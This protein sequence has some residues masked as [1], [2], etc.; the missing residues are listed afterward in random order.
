[1][2]LTK[3]ELKIERRR[4]HEIYLTHD[5]KAFREFITDR[6]KIKPELAP[7]ITATEEVLSELM[8][9]MKSQLMYLGPDWQ[10]ARNHLRYKQFWEDGD[11]AQDEIPE[12]VTCKWFQEAPNKTESS[13]MQMG[14]TPHDIA[15]KAFKPF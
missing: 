4:L 8:F 5:T 1:M 3:E 10:E 13:C 11:R 14:A 9:N 15:C 12:C 6:S 2:K 7:Y